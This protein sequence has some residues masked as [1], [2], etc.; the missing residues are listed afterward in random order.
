MPSANGVLAVN[1]MVNISPGANVLVGV[2]WLLLNVDEKNCAELGAASAIAA[3]TVASHLLSRIMTVT[4]CLGIVCMV[5]G[6]F[7]SCQSE[8]KLGAAWVPSA[9]RP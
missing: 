7:F 9:V 8:C 1:V 5:T 6:W 2:G 3:T 4:G